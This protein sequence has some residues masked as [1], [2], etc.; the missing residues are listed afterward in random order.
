MYQVKERQNNTEEHLNFAMVRF[1]LVDSVSLKIYIY[2]TYTIK[3]LENSFK[4]N[5]FQSCVK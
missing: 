5:A 2:K 4:T 1:N 3:K